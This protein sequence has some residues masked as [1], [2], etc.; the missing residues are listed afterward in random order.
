MGSDYMTFG[1]ETRAGFLRIV[2]VT[3]LLCTPLVLPAA[4]P[5]CESFATDPVASGRFIQTNARTESTF[6][7][8]SVNQHLA[9]T[10]DVD[11]S[12]A[13]YLSTPLAPATDGA[14]S[15]FS[16]RFRVEAF[17]DAYSPAAF[18]GLMT[19]THVGA[20][21]D[22]IAMVVSAANG[23]LVA[24]AQF[25]AGTAPSLAGDA[26]PLVT[27]HDYLA[28]GRYR[29][30]KRE[31]AVEV[32]D[33]TGFTN[34][35]GFS[36]R[37]L[38]PE[39]HVSVDR[40]GLQ[41][42]G[43]RRDVDPTTGSITLTVD[44]LCSPAEFPNR[45]CVSPPALAITEGSSGSTTNV[46]TVTLSPRSSQ[47]ITV[48]YRI[49]SAIARS[50][51][52]NMDF[53]GPAGLLEGTLK[54]PPDTA[55]VPLSVT[56]FGDLVFEPDEPITV[57]LRRPEGAILECA[58]ATLT[59]VNDDLPPTITIAT[60]SVVEGDSGLK[61]M[62]F[63]VTV[64]G[65]T[66]L[67]AA[68]SYRTESLSPPAVS[69]TP[70]T[71]FVPISGRM[72]LP[73]ESMV[74]N[75]EFLT[76]LTV[77]VRGD[78]ENETRGTNFVDLVEGFQVVL[79][80]LS[81]L[82]FG[83]DRARGFI[84][85]DDADRYVWIENE[86]RVAEGPAG[87]N[88]NLVF[89]VRLSR[90]SSVAVTVGLSTLSGT[91]I[92]EEDFKRVSPTLTLAPNTTQLAA[93]IEV[94]G[95]D[96]PEEDEYLEVFLRDP[97]PGTYILPGKGRARGWILNDDPKPVIRLEEVSVNEPGPG[98]TTQAAFVA[99]LSRAVNYRVEFAYATS[100]GSAS[101]TQ[102]FVPVSL[103][104][105][106]FPT[107]A[108]RVELSVTVKG[109]GLDEDDEYFWLRLS[110]VRDAEPAE[111]SVR[112]WIRD[113][114]PLPGLRLAGTNV[115]EGHT[116]TREVSLPVTLWP[117][118]GR[119]VRVTYTTRDNT[120]TVADHDYQ[121]VSRELR[122]APGQTNA[123]A[124][125]LVFGDT[126]YEADERFCVRLSNPV[127]ATNRIEEAEACVT[128]TNDEV[129]VPTL[130][131][132]EVP[133]VE[134]N[135]GTTSAVFVVQASFA[136]ERAVTFRAS[137]FDGTAWA[138]R[139]YV[140]F[141]N[142]SF[143][144]PA[145]TTRLEIPVEV[146]GDV[147]DEDNEYFTLRLSDIQNA[148][149][150]QVEARGTILDDDPPPELRIGSATVVEGNAGS[151]SVALSVTLSTASGREV[152]V[153][154]ATE[155]GTARA[156]REDYVPASGTLTFP[157]NQSSATI[158]VTVRGDV[159]YETDEQ[160][161]VRLSN[162]INATLVEPR[163]CVVI[164][165]DD[166]PPVLSVANLT[167][168]E[169]DSG[170][171]DAA[172][173][174]RLSN[175]SEVPVTLNYETQD[176]TALAGSDYLTTRSTAPLAFDW[177]A[178]TNRVR[179]P[180]IGDR[181]AESPAE[182]F[183]TLR[184][185]DV[186]TATPPVPN[187]EARCTI[188]DNDLGALRLIVEDVPE[189]REG[190]SG[191]QPA[192]FR[193][194]LT[195]AFSQDVSFD[196]ATE[197]G[198]AL[199]NNLDYV[200]TRGQATIPRGSTVVNIL[201]PVRGDTAV[202]PDEVFYLGVHNV[203]G[204]PNAGQ[205]R[206]QCTILDDDTPTMLL[207]A[208]PQL[209]V[210]EGNAGTRTNVMIPVLLSWAARADVLLRYRTQNR[211]ATGGVDFEART[212]EVR[213]PTGQQSG[214]AVVTVIGDNVVESDETFDVVFFDP[215]NARLTNTTVTVTIVDDDYTLRVAGVTL[216][217][218]DCQPGNGALD[219]FELVTLRVAVD[220]PGHLPLGDVSLR[221]REDSHL[222]LIEGTNRYGSVP[223]QGQPVTRSFRFQVFGQCGEAIR[224][225]WEAS[226]GGRPVALQNSST[227][228]TLGLRPDGTL[229]C[230]V[231]VDLRLTAGGAPDPVTVGSSLVYTVQVTNRGP[232][233]AN[234]V[235]LMNRLDG[236]VRFHSL[237]GAASFATNETGDVVCAL[238]T[239]AS[240][241]EA[242]IRLTVTTPGLA[243]VTNLPVQLTSAFVV[244]SAENEQAPL[245]NSASVVSQLVP[246]TGWSVSHVH[247][248]EGDSGTTT[249]AVFTVWRWPAGNASSVQWF[250]RDGT[251]SG[252]SDFAAV[253]T[254]RT[255]NFAPGQTANTN[256]VV[257]QVNG[258]NVP[259]D[260]EQFQVVLGNPADGQR[261]HEPGVGTI[262][263]DDLR[264]VLNHPSVIEGGPGD[265]PVLAFT[266]ALSAPA[267]EPVQFRFSTADGSATV[268]DSD[269][270]SVS[271]QNLV[272]AVGQSHAQTVP[273][274]IIGD[275][276]VEPDETVT[277]QVKDLSGRLLAQTNG[278]ILNDDWA[279]FIAGVT[280]VV[281]GAPG[282]TNYLVFVAELT[283]ASTLPV[284]CQFR[285]AD[286]S[287]TVADGDYLP[288]TD[289]LTFQPGTTGPL[290]VRVPV[291]GDSRRETNETVVGYL[292]DA[293][294]AASDPARRQAT[295]VITNDEYLPWLVAVGTTILAEGCRPANQAVDPFE[296]VV[297][298]FSLRN[299][300]LA[301]TTNLVAT[302][303]PETPEGYPV[304]P[305]T[306]SSAYRQI[307]VGSRAS[308][309]FTNR[310]V[311][312]CGA[313]FH[314]R[315]QLEDQGVFA[316]IVEFESRLGVEHSGV[317]TC[318][319]QADL[320]MVTGVP[321]KILFGQD[322][323]ATVSVVN[324][325][326]SPATDVLLRL[327]LPDAGLWSYATTQGACTRA[328]TL[329]TC[330]LG[331]LAPGASADLSLVG[332]EL[333]V[334]S[335][336]LSGVVNFS[337][338]DPDAG[339][340]S[341]AVRTEV[342]V[343]QG[344]SVE[345]GT[346]AEGETASVVV[347]LEPAATE[348]VQVWLHTADG[349]ATTASGDY[350]A[351]QPNPMALTFTRGMSVINVPV[352]VLVDL[353]DEP[354]P[355][356]FFNVSLTGATGATIC[357]DWQTAKIWI[358]DTDQPCLSV[359]DLGVD[360]G[361]T[362]AAE[363][364]VPVW[365]S[366][367]PGPGTNVTV[368]YATRDGTA[369]KG[370]DYE[371]KSGQLVFGSDETHKAVPIT[372]IGNTED[373]GTEYFFLE[374]TNAVNALY[375]K[376][377]GTIVITNHPTVF[378]PFVAITTPTNGSVFPL[379]T[380][381]PIRALATNQV[382]GTVTNVTFRTNGTLLAAA[383]APLVEG[384]WNG[385]WQVVWT[386][387]PPG[388]HELTAVA[389]DSNG[390]N[391]TSAPVRIT[392][393]GPAN[394]PPQI[395]AIPD[396][397]IWEDSEGTVS[398]TVWDAETPA[399]QLDV[400]VSSSN[401]RLLPPTG[402][403]LSGTSTNR[404]LALRPAHDEFT[405]GPSDETWIL[406]AVEDEDGLAASRLFKLTVLPVNDPP[407][408]T[409]GPDVVVFEDAGQAVLS[410]W[411]ADLKAGPA[412]ESDQQ[413]L[414]IQ[415][416]TA[417]T[418]L[419][420]AL[421][422]FDQDGTLRFIPAPNAFGTNRVTVRLQDT[423]GTD[424]GGVD[425]ATNTFTLQVLAVNDP[426]T[427][428]P[429]AQR[430]N[431]VNAPLQTVPLS[432][433][434]PGMTNEAQ[435]LTV[436]AWSD[437]P[438]LVEPLITYESPATTGT[439]SYQPKP[440]RSGV[441]TITVTV[442][443][444]GGTANGGRDTVQRQFRLT[445]QSNVPPVVNW[446]SPTNG[447]TFPAN[448]NLT[449]RATAW[450]PD[451]RITNVAFYVEATT[452]L[453]RDPVAPRT[454]DTYQFSWTGVPEGEYALEARATD[455][456]GAE[457]R[458]SPVRLSVHTGIRLA[459]TSPV[460]DATYCP[461]SP[462]VFAATAEGPVPP[463]SSVEFLGP[464]GRFEAA[465]NAP[466]AVLRRDGLPTGAYAVHAWLVDA[467][468]ALRAVSGTNRFMV[469]E[470]C[471]D[472][473]IVRNYDDPE[474]DRMVALLQADDR[475]RFFVRNG[476]DVFDQGGVRLAQLLGYK[477]IIWAGLDRVGEGLTD[478]DV[479]LFEA[480]RAA[481]KSL[482]FL[483]PHLIED[484]AHLSADGRAR[485]EQLAGVQPAGPLLAP[486]QLTALPSGYGDPIFQ[487]TPGGAVIPPATFAVPA[488]Q[489][490]E[491]RTEEGF[492]VK[493][494]MAGAPVMVVTP[495]VCDLDEGQVRLAT[496]AFGLGNF[497][498]SENLF[499]NTA[500]WLLRA[501][502]C[503]SFEVQLGLEEAPS[504]GSV[505]EELVYAYSIGNI[506]GECG[507]TGV[508]LREQLPDGWEVVSIESPGQS[509]GQVGRQLVVNVGCI[510]PRPQATDPDQTWGYEVRLHLRATLPGTFT[511]VVEIQ[512]EAEAFNP[513]KHHLEVTTLI[514]SVALV[515]LELHRPAPTRLRL[516]LV[517]T[518]TRSYRIQQSQ[519][520][521]HW[522]EV[523]E[524]EGPDACLDVVLDAETRFFRARWP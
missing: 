226:D 15:S 451:G 250:T 152:R 507:A 287:A 373:E 511:H 61:P 230:C 325:G 328:D 162:A 246:P 504:E 163:G 11:A 244:S 4:G 96:R 470:V 270:A 239:I 391:R 111:L 498:A 377:T 95:D 501:W 184:L 410:H 191:A 148:M 23:K 206:G 272:W 321:A 19:T 172:F 141:T 467:S 207:P 349:T 320:A 395:S 80:G 460:A 98:G 322:L 338:D 421:P 326:P 65:A 347:R 445:I 118:S 93:P 514:E 71:D 459:L 350:V 150:A 99:T 153:A 355:D 323:R 466:F 100:P 161:C 92:E 24:Q 402:L 289:H 318:C 12:P 303:L 59:I 177:N 335:H 415:V 314:Y 351:V 133:V 115:L 104:R 74:T 474:V 43:A 183:F 481:G 63:A 448:A 418:N 18:L 214:Q 178:T 444:N 487:T 279:V 113:R 400:M 339:N 462:I 293:V 515:R 298:S 186:A 190:D 119:E 208:P 189:I 238:G 364:Q 91:A 502:Y 273:V 75:V 477:L 160:F 348:I 120:A 125:V 346:V 274:T 8:E 1:A 182:E 55:T 181:V 48:D 267:K 342:V 121:Q 76:N 519:D 264:P 233:P 389:Q 87:R 311:G 299:D 472:V 434:T 286:G 7:W 276:R 512:A 122:F 101:E 232:N 431:R 102:D 285:T 40:L 241:A 324:R 37:S 506:G 263:D 26:I 381:L 151:R 438:S 280:N 203:T 385:L 382:S 423:G 508:T 185:F 107:N 433:I 143:T 16:V 69:A 112:G 454:N 516:C 457:V 70:D 200:S 399:A 384:P 343:C 68:F 407:S 295:G 372:I 254:P 176:G 2:G 523:G 319:S 38:P 409:P 216:A 262:Q 408:F 488:A 367:A 50:S 446:L 217:A 134:G 21:G 393:T 309:S 464:E 456:D 310:V 439:L 145:N 522:I 505:Q 358:R 354:L 461:G 362:G 260:D 197:D 475:M 480:L 210:L 228:V 164:R 155:D 117:P 6:A 401:A 436:S 378:P 266:V 213:I 277:A 308:R 278:L 173:V 159:V 222:R 27:G 478:A 383:T 54:F 268:A 175:P 292:T 252:T 82:R 236:R 132:A 248:R 20:G 196:Y 97:S 170:T 490:C 301:A 137:T 333:P 229:G 146:K 166:P 366:S 79:E 316:G 234:G 416:S 430:T 126:K 41:N 193:V 492:Q 46:F 427:L 242:I 77:Q 305:V 45:L 257:V 84:V 171:T 424:R 62:S 174:L 49:S 497:T 458:S 405:A 256:S 392:V 302:L 357:P 294:G 109:D 476:V 237:T 297:V 211:T 258:D 387:P 51:P 361:L 429:L 253:T 66:E 78:L 52:P 473:A 449:L 396:Q 331:S 271:S 489:P 317:T 426:P 281:E 520:L 419:F 136:P 471:A 352:T 142:V 187:P 493:L 105:T 517:G 521:A 158:P 123:P 194:V 406:V 44:E 336:Q 437:N 463:N 29:T 313:P 83:T 60:N 72:T 39:L 243:E 509:W 35:V 144:L 235:V 13:Y 180:V 453:G 398:F 380:D 330:V 127:N 57:E 411:A 261:L 88:T 422:A 443:D 56:V 356:E 110:D 215:S 452:F 245:D 157:A 432:G 124:T 275:N 192:V 58:Q 440:G 28:V 483:G 86:P 22:G 247:V 403:V 209:S 10:L 17:D 414:P 138:G 42:D 388:D 231:P 25:E 468:G 334:G 103:T 371:P 128:I 513:D 327:R 64:K 30:A 353:R 375:C 283:S 495:P 202:E 3:W 288:V 503:E 482:Y 81:N 255:I 359:G 9:S 390:L 291:I 496:Q 397:T 165:N 53:G 195:R 428:D 188:V 499:K 282:E 315:L 116:G 304:I 225:Q 14:D 85:D 147:L 204:L 376:P 129:L 332:A 413:L 169:G 135:A 340:N 224:L 465:T 212:N 167:V 108:T 417:P 386:N 154:Y 73:L 341:F 114:D 168:V 67:P 363:V 139:D 240:Q 420:A 227:T 130:T 36:T 149:P 425:A 404:S 484:A 94:F 450:D 370:T 89:E 106:E 394:T 249:N 455:N 131:L 219:P 337:G 220:N 306:A 486:A 369:V 205:P 284:T 290:L 90:P 485:W 32:F 518:D 296:T 251:A 494:A 360:V 5:L 412:N 435:S 223:A 259:E 201:V 199:T 221:L 312:P 31:L 500:L 140:A 510:G 47:E 447:Q 329:L 374:V 479:Q 442:T 379:G 269:Y 344:L 198:T 524:L 218:E 156:A 300:G 33:G 34:L 365:L 491:L 265:R 307:G 469:P 368:H 441:A 345:G 179:V